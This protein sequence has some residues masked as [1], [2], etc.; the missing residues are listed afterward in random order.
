MPNTS[1][2]PNFQMG[3]SLPLTWSFYNLLP[4]PFCPFHV[5]TKK[6]TKLTDKFLNPQKVTRAGIQVIPI[7]TEKQASVP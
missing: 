5:L 1:N 4:Q 7:N 2:A 6:M 3:A